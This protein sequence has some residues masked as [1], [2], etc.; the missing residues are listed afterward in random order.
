MTTIQD[1]KTKSKSKISK[2]TRAEYDEMFEQLKEARS[3]RD[4]IDRGRPAAD[5]DAME[6]KNALGW[7]ELR[8]AYQ[9]VRN[10]LVQKYGVSERELVS[11][12]LH[13]FAVSAN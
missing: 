11:L 7:V 1:T 9:V 12:V 10:R 3:V 4:W 8:P 2:M 6:V 5:V 13:K